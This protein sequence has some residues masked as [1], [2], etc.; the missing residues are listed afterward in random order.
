LGKLQKINSNSFL[1][2]FPSLLLPPR[3]HHLHLFSLFQTVLQTHE[4]VLHRLLVTGNPQP[5]QQ[6]LQLAPTR[7]LGLLV[8]VQLSLQ[9]LLGSRERQQYLLEVLEAESR[10]SVFFLVG[11]DESVGGSG[12][13]EVELLANGVPAP[14][15]ESSVGVSQPVFVIFLAIAV[16]ALE[17]V[18]VVV[19]DSLDGLLLEDIF[20]EFLV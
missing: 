5:L 11:L 10:P 1:F 17:L 8:I 12:V 15:L 18:F 19:K 2:H 16:K 20:H 7:L 3:A 6:L 4:I 14:T 13:G 9:L